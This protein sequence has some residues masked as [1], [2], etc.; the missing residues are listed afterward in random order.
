[1]AEI[2]IRVKMDAAERFSHDRIAYTNAKSEFVERV[3]R[4]ARAMN[5]VRTTGQPFLNLKD[6]RR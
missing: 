2:Y 6:R 1:M 4:L 5:L 3:I